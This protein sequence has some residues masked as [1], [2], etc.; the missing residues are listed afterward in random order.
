MRS[1]QRSRRPSFTR[2]SVL[3]RWA[4]FA[5]SGRFDLSFHTRPPGLGKPDWQALH[6]GGLWLGI[7]LLVSVSLLIPSRQRVY[8]GFRP[9][10]SPGDL[11]PAPRLFLLPMVNLFFFG[12]QYSHWIV[13]F[14]QCREPAHRLFLMGYPPVQLGAFRPGSDFPPAGRQLIMELCCL[15]IILED[16]FDN[17]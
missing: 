4:R 8:L 9:D 1:R 5:S 17:L 16:Y 7:V 3:S 11:V 12:H 10:V 14:P 2:S 13:P 15:T 6:F